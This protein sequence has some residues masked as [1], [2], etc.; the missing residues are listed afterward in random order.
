M[1]SSEELAQ[2]L[3]QFLAY[4]LPGFVV[5]LVIEWVVGLFKKD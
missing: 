2:A 5:M 1:T 4:F 3:I